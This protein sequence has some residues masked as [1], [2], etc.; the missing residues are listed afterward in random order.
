MNSAANTSAAG[1]QTPESIGSQQAKWRLIKKLGS[2][3]FGEIWLATNDSTKE[4]VAIKLEPTSSRHPQ[5][6]YESRVYKHLQDGV[7]IP[8]IKWFGTEQCWNCLVMELLG[9]SLEDL[10]NFCGRRFT[11]K[12][13]LMLADQ[14]LNRVEFVHAKNF[15]HR[16]IKPD[17]FLMGTARNCNKVYVIDFGLA[18]KY[19]D[20]RTRQHIEY[21][22][23][24]HLT[25][26][27]RYASINAHLGIEQSRRDDLESL[28]YVLMYF[29]RSQLPWQVSCFLALFL[30]SLRFF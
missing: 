3:S 13:V 22:E 24:K 26:T 12:T 2:G 8:R 15:I 11:I 9:P 30:L 23:D 27:A 17:N 6:L 28:G 29:L 25:G 5:L 18:K 19:R 1:L 20:M 21:R 7:G 14:M 4:E 16:D 10:F